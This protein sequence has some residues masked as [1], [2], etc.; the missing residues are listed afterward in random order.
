MKGILPVLINKEYVLFRNELAF[1]GKGKTAK[2]V[3]LSQ[4]ESSK[5]DWN[6]PDIMICSENVLSLQGVTIESHMCD[7][8]TRIRRLKRH[9]ESPGQDQADS[10]DTVELAWGHV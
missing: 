10:V 8:F 7:F 4:V 3:K 6:W 9:Q 1:K 2:I 5:L